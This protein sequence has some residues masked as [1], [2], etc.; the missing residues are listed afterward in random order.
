MVDVQA[1]MRD[2]KI[3]ARFALD[4]SQAQRATPASPAAA[5]E[6]SASKAQ[7]P[8]PPVVLRDTLKSAGPV[9]TGETPPR[10]P[11]TSA[12]DLTDSLDDL[13]VQDLA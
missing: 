7:S 5:T 10:A 3:Q 11:M 8:R 6:D 2:G 13:V 12:E 1:V 9:V 4:R